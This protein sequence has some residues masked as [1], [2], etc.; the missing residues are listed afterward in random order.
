MQSLSAP[1]DIAQRTNAKEKEYSKNHEN[2]IN[3]VEIDFFV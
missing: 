2:E 3:A 1:A